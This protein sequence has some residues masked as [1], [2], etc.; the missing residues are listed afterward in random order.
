MN[1]TV[2]PY[3]GFYQVTTLDRWGTQTHQVGKDKRCTC[4]GTARHPCRHIQAVSDYLKE[5]GK[6]APEPGALHPVRE[7]GPLSPP[8][9][10]VPA[11]C[12]IC[13]AP[14]HRELGSHWRCVADA[15]HYFLWRGE[16]GIRQFL[17]RPHPNKMGSFYEMS[18]EERDAFLD[19]AQ[20]RMHAGGY[21]PYD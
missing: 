2:T 16:Q 11:T 6:R 14:L 19:Q 21:T 15:S 20:R 9:S 7:R 10:P 12:P 3:V 18:Q 5:G 1:L 4:G 8:P 13:E 17:T